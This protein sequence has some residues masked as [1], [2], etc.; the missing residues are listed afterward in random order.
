MIGETYYCGYS[1]AEI[2]LV[3]RFLH[4]S[5]EVMVF[6]DEQ[7]YDTGE[8]LRIKRNADQFS[9]AELAKML[10][11]STTALSA[12]EN[13]LRPVPRRCE[14]AVERYLYEEWYLGKTLIFSTA[15]FLEDGQDRQDDEDEH[16]YDKNCY[17][18]NED[19]QWRL[20]R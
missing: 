14:K 2:D 19:D 12:I 13:G 1:E 7:Y 16:Y 3:M 15:E 4:S 20:W 8:M 5:R 17:L 18:I 11:L 9:Q 10:K 6:L